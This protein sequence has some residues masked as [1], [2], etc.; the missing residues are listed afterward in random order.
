MPLT[1]LG[2]EIVRTWGAAVL[3]PYTTMLTMQLER[4]LWSGDHR[5]NQGR[6]VIG[7]VEDGVGGADEIFAGG[8]VGSGVEVAVEAGEVAAAD[9]K[10]DDVTLLKSV[11][12]G[13]EVYGDFVD[14]VGID[15][16]GLFVGVAITHAEDS[17]G[18]IFGEAVGSDVNEH[19]GEV[20]VDGGGFYIGLEGNGAGDLHV[21]LKRLGGVDEHVVAIC[22]GALIARAGLVVDHVAAERATDAG[23]RI[24][25]IEG[26]FVG[27]FFFRRG[28]REGAVAAQGI[29]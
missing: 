23:D 24:R 10:A 17:V 9:L 3:R 22:G 5:E 11:G 29:G 4:S 28:G 27:G 25:R 18:E 13:P 8:L 1:L 7:V 12:G 14:L 15:E 16:V 6:G 26:E 2:V 19:G 20:G 21:L